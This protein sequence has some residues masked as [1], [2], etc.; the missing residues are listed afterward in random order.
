MDLSS[1]T[2]TYKVGLA[3][4]DEHKMYD[5]QLQHKWNEGDPVNRE[6]VWYKVCSSYKNFR[7]K[8]FSF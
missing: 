6:F 7:E 8:K 1:N 5:D 4:I 2:W 3:G